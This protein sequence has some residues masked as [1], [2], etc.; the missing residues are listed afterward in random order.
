MISV[1]KMSFLNFISNSLKELYCLI[2]FEKLFH[3]TV[4]L[5]LKLRLQQLNEFYL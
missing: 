3:N 1:S 2:Y 5:K 4:L